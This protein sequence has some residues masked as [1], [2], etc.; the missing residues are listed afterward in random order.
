MLTS[1]TSSITSFGSNLSCWIVYFDRWSLI[2]NIIAETTLAF[3]DQR[4]TELALTLPWVFC[5]RDYAQKHSVCHAFYLNVFA[6][7]AYEPVQQSGCPSEGRVVMVL[8]W[9]PHSTIICLVTCRSSVRFLTNKF[10]TVSRTRT[11][12]GFPHESIL[13]R[14]VTEAQPRQNQELH[15]WI[16]HPTVVNPSMVWRSQCPHAGSTAWHWVPRY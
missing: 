15:P 3:L 8:D 12:T 7:G 14:G 13:E 11:A 9:V 5:R 16:H 6:K 1:R 4:R 2:A 10:Q